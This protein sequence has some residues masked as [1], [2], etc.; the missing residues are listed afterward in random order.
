MELIDAHLRRPPPQP[1]RKISWIP[2]AF[3]S[4]LAKALAKDPE[5]RYESCEEMIRLLSRTLY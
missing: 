3:D 1:S 5:R 2:R 4:I